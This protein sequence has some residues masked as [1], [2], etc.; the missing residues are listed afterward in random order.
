MMNTDH[1]SK[2]RF[3]YLRVTAILLFLGLSVSAVLVGVWIRKNFSFELPQAYFS[4]VGEARS[5]SFYYY[6]FE[7]RVDRSGSEMPLPEGMYAQRPKL[8]ISYP[9]LPEDLKNAF[10]SIEDKRFYDHH[11]VDWYRTVGA[12]L[13]YLLG[14]SDHFG[15]STITQQLVKNL[16]GNNEITL[17][18]KLQEILYALDLER[19]LDKSEILTWYLNIIHFSDRC[20]G[21]AEA[22]AHYFSKDVQELTPAECA[23]LAAIANSPARYHPVRH[24]EQNAARRNLILSQMYEQGYL[25]EADYSKAKQEE[26][27]IRLST[28]D[29][30][31]EINSWYV[32]MVIEDVI[33]DLMQEYGMS[34]AEASRR[35]SLGGLQIYT[36]MD[37]TVQ[38]IVEDAYS[39]GFQLPSNANGE[40]AQSSII[41]IDAGT[42]DV[43]GVAGALGEKQGNL[44]QSF[45]TQTLRPPGSCLK[46]VS[47]YAP[48]LE[49][50]IINWASIYDDVPL[51]FSDD[52]KAWPKNATG[53]YR[54]LTTVS[55]A[56]AHSTNTVA[57]RVLEDLGIEESFRIAKE[58]F[59]LPLVSM[60]GANDCDYAA[61]GLGQLNYGVTLRDMTTAYTAFADGGVYHPWRSYYRVLDAEGNLLLSR[62]DSGEVA[63][64]DSTAAI[65]T[66]L[67]QGVIKEGTSSSVTLTRLT[68]CAGKTGT[69]NNDADRWFIGYTPEIICGVWC[70]YEYPEPLKGK[71]L[72]I[73]IWNDVMTEIV[74]NI[75]GKTRFEIPGNVVRASYCKD[76]GKRISET[77]LLDPRGNREEIGWFLSDKAPISLCD[78]HIKCDYDVINGGVAC[79]DC[80]IDVRNP[81]ALIRVERSFP[82][83]LFISDAQYVYRGDPRTLQPNPDPT[84]AYFA[85]YTEGFFGRSRVD[86]PYNRSCVDCKPQKIEGGEYEDETEETQESLCRVI[87]PL[88]SA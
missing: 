35:L 60:P 5:P 70:G 43:L 76:S 47:V 14:F 48:A 80:P 86:L 45:A 32:D 67:L 11:G 87:T 64:S 63:L 23:S 58:K 44:L 2:S 79:K 37:P 36:A 50:G 52:G 3:F 65:M 51:R 15:G 74:E 33:N 30:E 66:K 49:K 6:E 8:Q 27:G 73:G 31:R 7:D 29:S 4:E 24:P 17:R 34:R 1:R 56:V 13:N 28:A 18:R 61:L 39:G 54:G 9:E 25:S 41:L 40:S 68:E 69:T 57:L 26:L 20:D 83:D 85:P 59:H 75:G 38:K 71:N 62:P 88:K 82:R 21:V 19:R 77:C 46:P 55:Y 84:Q 22:A 16:T 42:G 78:R 53:I 81:T 12:G 72:C 10:L